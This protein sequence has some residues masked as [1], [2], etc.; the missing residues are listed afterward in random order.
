[1]TNMAGTP[2]YGK[3]KKKNLILQN[4]LAD[5]FETWYTA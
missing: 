2:I 1:M 5:G 4:Q 3:Y